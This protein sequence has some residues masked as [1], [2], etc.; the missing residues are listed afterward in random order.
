MEEEIDSISDTSASPSLSPMGEPKKV[1]AC[2][3]QATR[4]QE[5]VQ[6]KQKTSACDI[7]AGESVEHQQNQSFLDGDETFTKG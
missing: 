5:R 3:Q 1:G 6:K 2:V 7:S 4:K